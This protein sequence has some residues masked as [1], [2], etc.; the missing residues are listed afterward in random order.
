MINVFQTVPGVSV[1]DASRLLSPQFNNSIKGWAIKPFAMLMTRFEEFIFIDADVLF[2]QN[3]ETMFNYKLYRNTGTL[4]FRDRTIPLKEEGIRLRNYF[5]KMV[6]HPSEYAKSQRFWLNATAYEG[7]SGVIVMDKKKGGFFVLLLASIL[8][9]DPFKDDLYSAVHGDKESYW[10]S[11]EALGV[12]Y[13]WS[14]GAGGAIG[15]QHPFSPYIICGH[16]FH[17]DENW[18]PLWFNG[19]LILNKISDMGKDVI[20]GLTHYAIDRTM[21]KLKW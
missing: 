21:V 18:N 6:K 7:E 14:N 16:L 8:N 5:K 15:H 3:P 10:M 13:S 1:V 4:Y 17:V 12:P 20:Y 11:N 9:M 2:F 19:G